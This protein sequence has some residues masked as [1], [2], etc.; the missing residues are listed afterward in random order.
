MFKK[1]YYLEDTA[2]KAL[3]QLISD[4]ALA[5]PINVIQFIYEWALLRLKSTGSLKG[6]TPDM[7]KKNVNTKYLNDQV[8]KGDISVPKYANSSLAKAQKNAPDRSEKLIYSEQNVTHSPKRIK[9]EFDDTSIEYCHRLMG[10]TPSQKMNPYVNFTV[11]YHNPSKRDAQI[12]AIFSTGSDYPD[13]RP[14]SVQARIRRPMS[15]DSIQLNDSRI[16]LNQKRVP[17]NSVDKDLRSLII[18]ADKN[19]YVQKRHL[20]NLGVKDELELIWRKAFNCYDAKNTGFLSYDDIKKMFNDAKT[21]LNTEILTDQ[22]L[23]EIWTKINKND[24][25]K[26]D[27][28]TLFEMIGPM[29][30][31]NIDENDEN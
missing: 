31:Q 27:F 20:E 24:E 2:E 6:E 10:T 19:L 11:P 25:G 5:K 30:E 17:K 12:N 8:V 7:Y 13:H 15:E 18:A 4:M 14:K 21:D 23:L 22:V 9:T 26:V 29:L 16:Y 1:K 28:D 3:I